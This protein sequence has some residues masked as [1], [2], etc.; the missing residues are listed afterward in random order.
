M[1]RTVIK[2]W[3]KGSEPQYYLRFSTQ[4]K[5]RMTVLCNVKEV[6]NAKDPEDYLHKKIVEAMLRQFDG[7]KTPRQPSRQKTPTVKEYKEH[8][9]ANLSVNPK[10]IKIYEMGLAFFEKQNS[11]K[12]IG[13]ITN[14]S[15]RLMIK[16]LK[17]SGRSANTIRSYI[18]PVQMMLNYAVAEGL[19]AK[20]PQLEKPNAAIKNVRTYSEADLDRLEQYLESQK[21]T[22]GDAW[23]Q[24]WSPNRPMNNYRA[25]MMLRYFGLR[26]GEVWSLPLRHI[27]LSEMSI[28]IAAVPELDWKP[29]KDKEAKLPIV[30]KIREFL[31]EDLNNRK[32]DEKYFLDK[33][34][35]TPATATPN[36]L[37]KTIYKVLKEV[38]LQDAAKTLHGFR[39]S[40]ITH[41]LE[42]GVPVSDVQQI[43]RHCNIETTMGYLNKKGAS[44]KALETLQ[45]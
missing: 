44:S 26:A 11:D 29:K 9:L 36:S 45:R 34:D 25:L 23:V 4:N 14:V 1:K 33:G 3:H 16:E 27:D 35:G 40:A 19:L 17:E 7:L 6:E 10:T 8:W 22:S 5:E 24:R 38:G 41:M 30:G 13:E 42:A 21:D 12:Q 2:K 15:T 20:A 39:A 31:L 43:A 32:A 18:K 28:T 37:N